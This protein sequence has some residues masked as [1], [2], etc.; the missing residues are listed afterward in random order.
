MC[1]YFQFLRG[2]LPT[3]FHWEVWYNNQQLP[4]NGD[5]YIFHENKLLGLPR[6]RQVMVRNDSCSVHEYFNDIIFECYDAY[7]DSKEDK[8]SD[9]NI[10]RIGNYTA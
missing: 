2:P 5:G 10:T 3:C 8:Y 7:S 6:I 9:T 1:I 4:K